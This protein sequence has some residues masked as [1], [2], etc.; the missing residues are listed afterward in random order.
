MLMQLISTHSYIWYCSNSVSIE[1]LNRINRAGCFVR[2]INFLFRRTASGLN[3]IPRR[4]TIP[5]SKA[6]FG[7]D[8]QYWSVLKYYFSRLQLYVFFLLEPK[9]SWYYSLLYLLIDVYVIF[10]LHNNRV[11]LQY[12]SSL[13]WITN[14]DILH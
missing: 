9:L 7:T 4:L 2:L 14:T 5:L 1:C 6:I 11:W 10:F 13:N 12:P 3:S 8:Y